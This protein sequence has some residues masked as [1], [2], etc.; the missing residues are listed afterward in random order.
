MAD[1]GGATQMAV[2]GLSGALQCPE[3]AIPT[4]DALR[5]GLLYLLA[6]CVPTSSSPSS[7]PT[8]SRLTGSGTGRR[9]WP[10]RSRPDPCRPRP[11]GGRREAR[12]LSGPDVAHGPVAEHPTGT[13]EIASEV[14]EGMRR[15]VTL[16]EGGDGQPGRGRAA[17]EGAILPMGHL[18]EGP[19]SVYHARRRIPWRRQNAMGRGRRAL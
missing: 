13:A 3:Q 6:V 19:N 15:P 18:Q 4:E 5:R 1:Q 2:Q 14:A 8:G 12:K 17:A 11:A 9:R 16:Q 10:P 7:A